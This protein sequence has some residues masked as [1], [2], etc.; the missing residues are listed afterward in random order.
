VSDHRPRTWDRAAPFYDV[1]LPLERAA[2][3]AALTLAAVRA[4][5]R[6]LDLA[7]GTAAL[8]R[9]LAARGG[10]PREAVGVDNS[11]AMLRAAPALPRGWRLVH[12]DATALPFP[13]ESFDVVIAAYLLHLLCPPRRRAV[14]A[15]AARVLRPAGR[16]VV[17][18]VVMPRSGLLA[19]AFR[20]LARAS[21]RHSGIMSGMRA[22]DPRPDLIDARFVIR[23][24]RRTA[25]GY[26]SLAVLAERR[27]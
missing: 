5:E 19:P 9:L 4:N 15:E 14:L 26:P 20:G 10:G 27:G 25:H 24:A 2:L 7:T 23:A 18:T 13:M 17:V 21:P 11:A 3:R 12:G 16:L 6:L 1:Q 8:L 22:L